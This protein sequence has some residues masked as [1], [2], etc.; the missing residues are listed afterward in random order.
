VGSSQRSEGAVEVPP[1]L[2]PKDYERPSVFTV[3]NLLREARRQRSLAD[4]PVPSVCLLDPDGDVVRHLLDRGAVAE[5]PG[6]ACYHTRMWTTSF[7]GV[8]LGVVPFAVGGPFAVLVAEELASSGAQLVISV[9]SAGRVLPV[10]QPPYFILVRQAWRDE[11]V[12]L[13]YQPPSQ[14]SS[15]QPHLAACLVG[16]F[17]G[18]EETV[19]TGASWTTDAP[20]RETASAIA[21]ARSAGVHAVE[22]EAAG[23]YAY[24]AARKRDVVCVAHVTN[25]MAVDGDDFEKGQHAGTNRILAVTAAITRAWANGPPQVTPSNP[26]RTGRGA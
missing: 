20:F 1:I 8:E 13:H 10:A 14:W 3:D 7:G 17:D 4:L 23:L 19:V 22:M 21:A 12:S 18:L 6:W 26:P 2:C 9:S 5:H 15:L 16:A 11:G 25:T 24:A